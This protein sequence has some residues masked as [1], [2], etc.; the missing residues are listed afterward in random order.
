MRDHL[1]ACGEGA[2]ERRERARGTDELRERVW[3]RASVPR[4]RN[5]DGHVDAAG[6]DA[7]AVPGEEAVEQR[8]EPRELP[9]GDLGL[10]RLVLP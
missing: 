10:P 4:G 7:A 5:H 3:R 6:R 2:E 8:R 1:V 9:R